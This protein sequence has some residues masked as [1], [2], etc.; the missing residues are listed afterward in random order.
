MEAE[1]AVLEAQNQ[2]VLQII[3]EAVEA[4]LV[5]ILMQVE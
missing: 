2:R 3:E 1:A 5:G 4:V